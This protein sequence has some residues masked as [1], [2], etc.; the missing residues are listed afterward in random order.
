MLESL[1]VKK[2][3]IKGGYDF[4]LEDLDWIA[5]LKKLESLTLDMLRFGDKKIDIK[6]CTTECKDIIRLSGLLKLFCQKTESIEIPT[7][8]N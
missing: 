1:H 8:C 3:K 6:V 4:P 5:N 2:L 7:I